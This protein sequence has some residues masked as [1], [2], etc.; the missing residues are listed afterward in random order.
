MILQL[1]AIELDGATD[2]TASGESF[3]ITPNDCVELLEK[4]LTE[5]RD[6]LC[7]ALGTASFLRLTRRGDLAFRRRKPCRESRPRTFFAFDRQIPTHETRQAST[8]RQ[9]EPGPAFAAGQWGF[10]LHEWLEHPRQKLRG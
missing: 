3:C 6:S 4:E 10:D 7:I 1:R 5:S 9:A 8:D 2:S